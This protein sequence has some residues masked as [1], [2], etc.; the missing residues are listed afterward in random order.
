MNFT[1]ATAILALAGLMASPVLAS[2]EGRQGRAMMPQMPAFAELDADG[3]GAVTLD[4]WRVHL[5]ARMAE[6]REA[7]VGAQVERLMAGDTDG[8]G[9]LSADELTARIE[10]LIDERRAAMAEARG[11]GRRG[12]RGEMRPEMRREMRGEMRGHGMGRSEMRGQGPRSGA[13]AMDA[14]ERIVRSFERLDRDGDGRITEAEYDRAVAWAN[15]RME[16]RSERGEGRAP[17]G[18][19]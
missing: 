14:D 19:D 1:T 5:T 10:A 13:M 9:L 11:E 3:D 4:E 16:R 15:Q 7:R 6:R 8:D 12:M 17:R 18:R 2:T